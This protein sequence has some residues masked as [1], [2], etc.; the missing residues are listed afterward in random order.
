MDINQLI[1]EEVVGYYFYSDE[2]NDNRRGEAELVIHLG[3]VE[4]K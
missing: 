1:D 4:K 2:T 3:E